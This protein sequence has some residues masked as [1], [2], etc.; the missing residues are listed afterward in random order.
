MRASAGGRGSH[1]PARGRRLLLR[2]GRAARRPLAPRQARDRRR[3]GRARR[4]LRGQGVR[5][6][7]ADGRDAGPA[8]LPA[9][10][11]RSPADGG[12]QRSERGD[13]RRLPRHHAA[14]GR[15][16]DRRG[17]PG[18]RRAAADLRHADARSPRACA[19]TVR[20]RV[21]I[22]VTV[23]VARTKFLAKVASGV[24]KPDGLLVVPVDDELAFLHALP[25]ERLWG[26]G[27]VTSKKLRERSL[28]TVA[29]VARLDEAALIAD[30][31]PRLG[32][33]P[34]RARAQPRPAPGRGRPAAS[35]DR[36]PAG[37]R[38]ARRGRPR[39]LDV[40]LIAL[41]DRLARRLRNAHRVSPD[42]HAPPAVRRLLAGD[43]VA[44]APRGHGRYGDV[45]DRR[46]RPARRRPAR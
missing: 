44:H 43:A 11:R 45:A 38:P 9:G 27:P 20:E 15:P 3:R 34:P 25:V 29:D 42:G 10:D 4:Q 33:P 24:A 36:H 40:D 26:V 22:R 5:R 41:V 39:Q 8:P 2:V 31:R 28:T 14:R 6:L 23:G 37:A 18:R 7:H 1:D 35:L 30:P 46:P 13:V 19:T 17:V 12:V 16:L 21:G 32:P